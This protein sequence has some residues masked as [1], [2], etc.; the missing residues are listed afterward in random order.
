MMKKI[1]LS[2]LALS[3][4][5]VAAILIF[6]LLAYLAFTPSTEIYQARTPLRAITITSY[7][8]QEVP[9]PDS[10]TGVS[11]LYTWKIGPYPDNG[12]NL[13][14]YTFHQYVRV[15]VDGV[16]QYRLDKARDDQIINTPGSTWCFF[17]IYQEDANKE[18]CIEIIP[19]YESARDR[20]PV[21]YMGTVQDIFLITMRSELPQII[22]CILTVLVGLI[23]L[24]V[25]LYN[26]ITHGQGKTLIA[27]GLFSVMLGIWKLADIRTT[28]MLFPTQTVFLYY[29]SVCML[30][31]CAVPLIKALSRRVSHHC[32]QVM[33]ICCILCASVCIIQ[34]LL[35]ILGILDLR[36]TLIGTH[37][38]IVISSLLAIP[39]LIY[40]GIAFPRPAKEQN[41][42]LLLFICVPGAL[43]DIIL[44]YFTDDSAS[45]VFTLAAHLIYTIIVGTQTLIRANRQEME[46]E[47]SQTAVLRSQIQP[48]FLFNSLTAIAQLCEKDPALAKEATITFSEYYRG[49]LRAI[50]YPEPI[51]FAQELE[52]LKMYL[53]IE[54]L[55]FG[56]SLHVVFD[57]ETTDFRI[58]ALTIQPLVENAVK[59]GVGA[60]EEGGT[61]EI[62]VKERSDGVRIIIRDDGVGFDPNAIS[63]QD[64]QHV[65][66]ENVKKRLLLMCDSTLRIQSAPGEG[67]TITISLPKEGLD[68]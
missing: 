16:E 49:N 31:L 45:L 7:D 26:Y 29:T 52:H 2:K 3:T 25:G 55:R 36:E 8:H 32:G 33:N 20:D 60:K 64:R 5:A 61:V 39:A 62:S 63:N 65:G 27:H 13:G 43:L 19:V 37:V 47:K 41:Y 56:D 54:Q 42:K 66:L 15:Y 30:S 40:D 51:P 4:T 11:C 17:P 10:P 67:T 24:T 38:S 44:F 68:T 12:A 58:P 35:Q 22:L 50:D 23:F 34:H 14:I 57:I 46:I 53:F 21:I 18:I 59:H 1:S 48:H 6:S 9:N 28:A